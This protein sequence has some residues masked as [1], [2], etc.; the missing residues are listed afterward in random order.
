VP[1]QGAVRPSLAGLEDVC[2]LGRGEGQ[3]I[4]QQQRGALA[5]RQQLDGGQEGE[6]TALADLIAAHNLRR[7]LSAAYGSRSPE[8][9]PV[10]FSLATT[11]FKFTQGRRTSPAART[12][13]PKAERLDLAAEE[14]R[15]R[16]RQ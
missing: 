16:I 11:W 4:P 13:S 14:V 9:W 10:A 7:R 5:R 15:K 3:R 2:G 1:L 12:N 8:R 6:L